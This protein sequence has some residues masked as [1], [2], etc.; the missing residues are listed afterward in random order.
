M[1]NKLP[2]KTGTALMSIGTS[3]TVIFGGG[4]FLRLHDERGFEGL[5]LILAGCFFAVLVGGIYMTYYK[6]KS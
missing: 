1:L 6:K 2:N 5:Y 3:G 4:F